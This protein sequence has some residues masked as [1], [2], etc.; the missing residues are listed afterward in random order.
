MNIMRLLRTAT[1]S[2][3]PGA[4]RGDVPG[5]PCSSAVGTGWKP[6]DGKVL[7]GLAYTMLAAL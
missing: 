3:E 2:T 5:N 4:T 1:S 7:R 6:F